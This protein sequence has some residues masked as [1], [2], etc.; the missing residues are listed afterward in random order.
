[1][2]MRAHPR[3]TGLRK[4]DCAL[5]VRNSK[6]RRPR[7]YKANI[8]GGTIRGRRSANGGDDGKAFEEYAQRL[9]HCMRLVALVECVRRE[10]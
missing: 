4:D 10:S 6:V 8:Y 7:R 2:E 1:V 9:R 5:W 3:S